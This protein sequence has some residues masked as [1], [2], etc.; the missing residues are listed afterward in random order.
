[1]VV[2][3]KPKILDFDDC[4]SNIGQN[5]LTWLT[6]S[7]NFKWLNSIFRRQDK[8]CMVECLL[9]KNYP[10][11]IY[12]VRAR[13]AMHSFIKLNV[14]AFKNCAQFFCGANRSKVISSES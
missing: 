13:K 1:M 9:D 6:F 2:Q 8:E 10:S 3:L 4:Q 5:L 11:F 14:E 7:C 12:T